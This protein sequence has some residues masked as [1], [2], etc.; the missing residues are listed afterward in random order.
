MSF[1]PFNE[2]AQA[3]TTAL[4]SPETVASALAQANWSHPF[5]F[6]TAASDD[7][8]RAHTQLNT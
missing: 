4:G 5:D 8:Q 6:L 3:V 2:I 1:H 7:L